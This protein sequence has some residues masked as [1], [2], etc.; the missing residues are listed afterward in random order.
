MEDR[1]IGIEAVAKKLVEFKKLLKKRGVGY[2]WDYINDFKTFRISFWY[3]GTD[4]KQEGCVYT[5]SVIGNI[6]E[7]QYN[8]L[9]KVISEL[10]KYNKP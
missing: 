8:M 5:K 7:V 3:L 9:I 6:F 1:I 10:K 4:Y 2:E